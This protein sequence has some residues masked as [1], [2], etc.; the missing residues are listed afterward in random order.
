MP[1]M[2]RQ[3]LLIT[4]SLLD[5]SHRMRGVTSVSFIS[6]QRTPGSVR[7]WTADVHAFKVI[8]R[9]IRSSGMLATAV[10]CVRAPRKV[11]L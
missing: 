1:P 10:Q 11:V 8:A 2:S 6:Q 9:K 5:A 3:L 7:C 4:L